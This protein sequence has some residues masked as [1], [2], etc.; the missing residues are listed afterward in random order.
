MFKWLKKKLRPEPKPQ[1]SALGAEIMD[2]LQED[3]W[4]GDKFTIK[5]FKS[6][7]ELWMANDG[8]GF[9][10]YQQAANEGA[11]AVV[12]RAASDEFE[13]AVLQR[14]GVGKAH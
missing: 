1:L 13:C 8:Y 14:E 3:T 12:N 4:S 5:H 9:R 11:L 6:G 2:A 7:L 10:I